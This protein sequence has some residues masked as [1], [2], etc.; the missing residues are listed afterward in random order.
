MGK[1]YAKTT[2]YCALQ[3]R[4]SWGWTS[5]GGKG[6]DECVQ[7]DTDS[8][9]PEAVTEL[10]AT[11]KQ[12]KEEETALK[13]EI[14]SLSRC[15]FLLLLFFPRTHPAQPKPRSRALP[16]L[17][18]SL[19]FSPTSPARY[20][21]THLFALPSLTDRTQSASLSASLAP[22]RDPTAPTITTSSLDTLDSFFSRTRIIAQKRRK[23]ALEIQGM[24]MDQGGRRKGEERELWEEDIGGEWDEDEV[25]VWKE[26]GEVEQREKKAKSG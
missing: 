9:D 17:P 19:L 16:A 23:I 14:K 15:A 10:E 18:L 13:E 6:A 12:L 21:S 4:S 8:L 1:V 11:I 26:V 7:S 25:E 22:L 20:A 2:V 3:V 5:G 24:L